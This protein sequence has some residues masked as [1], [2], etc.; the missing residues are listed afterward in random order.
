MAQ[1]HNPCAERGNIQKIVDFALQTKNVERISAYIDGQPAA[2]HVPLQ[3]KYVKSLLASH[4]EIRFTIVQKSVKPPENSFGRVSVRAVQNYSIN[5]T[6]NS[7]NKE[8]ILARQEKKSFNSEIDETMSRKVTANELKNPIMDKTKEF[9][10]VKPS[11]STKVTVNEFEDPNTNNLIHFGIKPQTEPATRS[12]FRGINTPANHQIKSLNTRP[13]SLL[14]RPLQIQAGSLHSPTQPESLRIVP[15]RQPALR[16]VKQPELRPAKRNLS[17]ETRLSKRLFQLFGEDPAE[18]EATDEALL[19]ELF[20][21][22]N[23]T[24]SVLS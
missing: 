23:L 13:T 18:V 21:P 4:K 2:I 8:T 15:A 16:P 5:S 3:G 22:Q 11:M 10:S 7:P 6:N 20:L 24:N 19:E 14:S 9:H 12:R 1:R 17:P